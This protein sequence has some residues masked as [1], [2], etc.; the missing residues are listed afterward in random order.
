M[1]SVSAEGK[2]TEKTGVP[3]PNMG[4]KGGV[5]EGI[6]HGIARGTHTKMVD[7]LI[8]NACGHKMGS[9]G[10]H[11]VKASA[12]KFALQEFGGVPFADAKLGRK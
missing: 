9:D 3:Q 2:P 7:G 11:A 12:T 1:P 4:H 6:V 10:V 8:G 5:M